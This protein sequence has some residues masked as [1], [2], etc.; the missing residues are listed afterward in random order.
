MTVTKNS[1]IRCP[2]ADI[3]QTDSEIFLIIGKHSFRRGKRFKD[4][5]IHIQTGLL[6]GVDQVPRVI[7]RGSYHMC[8]ERQFI[9]GHAQ[10]VL[11]HHLVVNNI[12]LGYDMNDLAVDTDIDVLYGFF[13][14]DL[15]LF[16]D[17]IDLFCIVRPINGDRVFRFDTAYVISCD[18]D[19]DTTDFFQTCLFDGFRHGCLNR[20]AGL[21][22]IDD[23]SAFHTR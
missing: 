10:R 6:H 23:N 18:T 11:D 19:R 12:F 3:D 8:F 9:A 2:A 13:K 22:D 17:N 14:P 4:N 15:I 5:I 16:I 20:G 21:I 1:Y 7:D